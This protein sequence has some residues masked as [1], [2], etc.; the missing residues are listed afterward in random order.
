MKALGKWLKENQDL[1]GDDIAWET[2]VCTVS[3]VATV[4][5]SFAFPIE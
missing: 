1:Y 5:L 3:I 4:L 2:C